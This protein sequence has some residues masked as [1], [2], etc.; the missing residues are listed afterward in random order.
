[1][2]VDIS[3]DSYPATDFGVLNG[4]VKSIAS[5]ALAPNQI[6]NRLQYMYPAMIRLSR[7]TLN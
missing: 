7:Q 2:P 3:I 6:E 1:M 5:D 4:E